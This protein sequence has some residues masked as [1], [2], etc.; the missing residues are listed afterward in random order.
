MRKLNAD[1]FTHWVFPLIVLVL[2]A[3]VGG[4][5][6]HTRSSATTTNLSYADCKLLGRDF[7]VSSHT[8]RSSCLP[9]AGIIQYA[10]VYDY[11]SN[12]V[13]W[14]PSHAQCDNLNRKWAASGGCA[15][16]WTG[17]VGDT[18][19]GALQ[20]QGNGTDG[21]GDKVYHKVSGFDYCTGYSSSPGGTGS[22]FVGADGFGSGQCTDYIKYILLRHS[23]NY[24]S[25]ASLGD[26]KDVATTLGQYGYNVNH[27]PAIH[28]TVSF[29]TAYAD[30]VH[31]HVAL[32][33]QIN[34]DGTIVTEESNWSNPYHYGTHK[35]VP[36]SEV[37]HLT[38]AHTEVGWH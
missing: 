7:V 33:A 32:V 31:G 23:S 30:P 24:H 35:V 5:V 20:C 6:Y 18:I 27:T 10:P 29:G 26:G 19:K 1:G 8:C 37:P 22:N 25:G 2:I 14:G 17:S 11:C 34:Q 12:A 4:Y 16:H 15:R 9:N 3:A 38:Y 21:T 28:A 13:A 36:A